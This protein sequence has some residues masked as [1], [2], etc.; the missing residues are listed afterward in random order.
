MKERE[1][2]FEEMEAAK[3]KYEEDRDR[4]WKEYR[5]RWW[6]VSFLFAISPFW[7]KSP[8]TER[9]PMEGRYVIGFGPLHLSVLLPWA[10]VRP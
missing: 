7:W 6:E 1:L 9:S 8:Y 2:A 3:R 10:R 4:E 5:S